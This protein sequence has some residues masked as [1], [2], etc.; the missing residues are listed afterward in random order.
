[1]PHRLHTI[2][3]P[4]FLLFA[5][6][7][8][9]SQD[10]PDLESAVRDNYVEEVEAARLADVQDS[11]S[12]QPLDAY[13][14][15]MS[16][17]ELRDLSAAPSAAAFAMALPGNGVYLRI[18]VFHAKTAGQVHQ[19]VQALLAQGPVSKVILD[20]RGNP[21]GLL[22]AAVEVADEFVERGTLA[23]TSGRSDTANLVFLAKPGGLLAGR[24]VAVLIDAKTAS[25]A[26]LLAGIL[27]LNGNAL[28]VGRNSFGKSAVQSQIALDNGTALSLTT[29]HYRFSDG[30]TVD[31]EGLVPGI[32]L[33]KWAMRRKP[34]LPG[35]VTGEA[36]LKEDDAVRKAWKVL[37]DYYS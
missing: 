14:H 29:A 12:L 4:A 10:N 24:P 6:A 35:A 32:A 22:N 13:S 33:P 27:A 26:E 15:Y 7:D 25:A 18:P 34:P 36:L 19:A 17:Q 1:M 31:P 21:G 16:P 11:G 8:A 37:N 9:N 23:E 5:M 3:L 30:N 2:I 28:L 20:L